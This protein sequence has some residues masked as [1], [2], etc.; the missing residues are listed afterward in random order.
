MTDTADSGNTVDNKTFFFK[1]FKDRF[2]AHD[3]AF[4][5][6]AV[7]HRHSGTEIQIGDRAGQRGI[8]IRRPSAIV[9]I[10]CSNA[11]GTDGKLCGIAFQLGK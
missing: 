2:A 6:G 3:G 11:I 5:Q 9:P 1:V 8:S 7:D 10:L 4:D